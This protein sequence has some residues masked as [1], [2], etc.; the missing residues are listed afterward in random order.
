MA[1][2]YSFADV[3]SLFPRKLLKMDNEWQVF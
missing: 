1:N 3:S 2:E